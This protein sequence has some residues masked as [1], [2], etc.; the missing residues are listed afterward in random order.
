MFEE[1]R[2]AAGGDWERSCGQPLAA[3]CLTSAPVSQQWPHLPLRCVH[4]CLP[5]ILWL[6]H[7]VPTQQ[8]YTLLVIANMRFR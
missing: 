6:E 3:W 8:D 7:E 1:A 5:L 2:V 4:T